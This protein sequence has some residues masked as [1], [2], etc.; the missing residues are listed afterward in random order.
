M[1]DFIGII[2][3]SKREINAPE[4]KSN[5]N[6]QV[7][8]L[9]F[10]L[11][12]K[13]NIA[14]FIIDSKNIEIFIDGFFYFNVDNF[15]YSCQN[16]SDQLGK[17]LEKKANNF[18][19]EISGDYNIILLD[20]NN[21]KINL[22][23]SHLGMLPL[24]YTNTNN[25]FIFSSKIHLIQSIG[26][27]K[28]EVDKISWLEKFYFHHFIGDNT[29]IK[30]IKSLEPA[31]CIEI[32]SNLS[33]TNNKYWMIDSLLTIEKEYNYKES[34]EIIDD[35]IKNFFKKTSSL[36][37]N[38]YASL[39]GGWDGRLL[40]AYLSQ[41]QSVFSLYSFG[42]PTSPDVIIPKEISD[43]CSFNYEPVYL[44]SRYIEDFFLGYAKKTILESDGQRSYNRAHYL[45]AIEKIANQTKTLLSGN[46]GSNIFKNSKTPDYMMN[47]QLLELLRNGKLTNDLIKNLKEF[48]KSF[49]GFSIS[50]FEMK[51][52]IERLESYPVMNKSKLSENQRFYYFLLN[53]IERK[54]F[55][56]EMNTYRSIV[57]NISFFIDINFL[58]TFTK[59]Q[60]FGS[61][62]PFYHK[63]VKYRYLATKL[64]AELI[65]RNNP[66]L[67][68]FSSDKGF[69]LDE[70]YNPLSWGII[71]LRKHLKSQ[72]NKK[73]KVD[74][75][76]TSSLKT[77]F[78]EFLIK[79]HDM[80]KQILETASEDFVSYLYYKKIIGS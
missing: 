14:S 53:D 8:D 26:L 69:S 17:L 10:T 19:S 18:C 12:S 61:H 32:K 62:L 64:Y 15:I 78:S 43:Y 22:Y 48:Q 77:R 7:N 9:F 46:C 6:I 39:T 54:Y 72:K 60:Y 41:Q 35:A 37:Q 4:F 67:L 25:S 44:D 11:H 70:V 68:K 42:A 34:I 79:E 65:K 5:I 76:N 59:T 27:L 3:K 1:A 66:K 73:G 40:L 45:Y 50:D 75:Y 28:L 21:S 20:K 24:Y 71:L 55:G 49:K 30:E 63:D 2:S 47:H 56:V 74:N 13:G 31:T 36:I 52:F 51:D 57:N 33:I 80:E 16:I 38:P 29:G 23:S 58:T